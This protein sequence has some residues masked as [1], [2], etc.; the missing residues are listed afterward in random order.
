MI[1]RTIRNTWQHR[2][3]MVIMATLC[4]GIPTCAAISQ[5]ESDVR[6]HDVASQDPLLERISPAP[7]DLL[8]RFSNELNVNV[9]A[10]VLTPA[11]RATLA[12]PL[13][14]TPLHR[15]VL[16]KRLRAIYFIDGFP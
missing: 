15:E 11:E 9:S 3:A 6:H 2:K 16:Q 12:A 8:K 7:E 5:S 13:A 4:A 1:W 14:Q 10:H